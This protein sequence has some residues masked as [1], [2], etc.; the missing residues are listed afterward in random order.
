MPH[1]RDVRGFFMMKYMAG[2]ED[3]VLKLIE[4]EYNRFFPDNPFDH[5]FLEDYYDQQ[6]K[7]EKLL[8]RIL[9]IFSVLSIIITCLGIFG[10]TAYLLVQKSKE[11]SMRQVLGS[12]LWNIIMLFSKDFII[13]TSISF[14]LAVPVS[15]YWIT[16]W[17]NS[18]E[19]KVAIT[20]WNF[21]L[22]YIAALL[23]TVIT[24]I[25]IVKRTAS[26]NPS[27]NLRTE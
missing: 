1:G 27:D 17:L 11:I 3:K 15:Y 9:A 7:D 4:N 6:Y 26:M 8:G 10:L 19:V 21:V 25:I 20:V 22:P 12:D 2:N 5:F 18:F 24:I 23:M 14:L 13:F 16:G